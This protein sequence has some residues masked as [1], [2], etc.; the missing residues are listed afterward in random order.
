MAKDKTEI[1]IKTEKMLATDHAII[2]VFEK[3]LS[4]KLSRFPL[5]TWEL[6][7]SLHYAKI[8]TRYMFEEKL[9]WSLEDIK[10]N[11]DK[12]VI[13][14]F[15]LAGMFVILF[16]SFYELINNAYPDQIKPWE[17]N[18]MPRGLW[19]SDDMKR[20]AIKWLFEEKLNWTI[21]DIKEKVT[22]LTFEDNGFAYLLYR[23][24]DSLYAAINF[25]Y[26]NQIH[27]WELKVTSNHY[28]NND[29]NKLKTLKWLF[30]EKLKW[31]PEEI[32]NNLSQKPFID[33]KLEGFLMHHFSGSPFQ[34]IDFLYPNQFNPWDFNMTMMDFWSVEENRRTALTWLFEKKLKWNKKEIN[35]K[36]NSDT[37]KEHKMT[38][39]F[40]KHFSS[41]PYKV[42]KF[43]YPDYDFDL[44]RKKTKIVNRI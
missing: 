13:S 22:T 37:F 10:K 4:R 25:A 3:V 9:K 26:P 8:I 2:D 31:T 34:A 42:A 7:N 38:R 29:E 41:S 44:L 16:D 39:V 35:Q 40:D 20:K 15:R 21:E 1:M 5:F 12:K 17:L 33:N 6:P 43:I 18:K 19:E 36:L 24:F 30:E 14:N 11:F 23:S 32:K 27:P 28:W